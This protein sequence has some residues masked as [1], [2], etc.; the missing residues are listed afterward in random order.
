M[1]KKVKQIFS[2]KVIVYLITR[3]GTFFIQFISS[4]FLAVNCGAYYFGIWGFIS[5]LINYISYFNLGIPYSVNIL[6]IQNKSNGKLVKDY[7]ANSFFLNVLLSILIILFGVYYYVVGISAFDK[8]Q[9]SEYFY[10]ICVIGIVYHFDSLF[11]TI[12]RVNNR[13]FELAF[14]QSIVPVLIFFSI[15]LAKGEKLLELLLWMTLSGEL[16]ALLIF[17]VNKKIP[18]GGKVSLKGVRDV[19][20]KGFHLFI[21]NVCFFLIGLSTRTIISLYYRVEDFG[22]F[23]FSYNLANAILLFLQAL[24]VVIF[25]KIIDKLNSNK[26][27]DIIN[28][29]NI[30]NIN[31]VTLSYG[32]IFIAMIFFPIFIYFIPKYQ[33][34]LKLINLV[35]IS[36]LLFTN[37]FGYGTYLMAQNQEKRLSIIS[38]ISLILNIVISVL[39]VI[40]FKLTYEYL[41]LATLITYFVF[42][43]CC[44]LYSRK[45]LEQKTNPI[46]VI[47]DFFPLR[48]L[49]PYL[50]SVL[51]ILFNFT[52]LI[53]LPLLVFIVLNISEIKQIIGT[54]KVIILRPTIVDIDKNT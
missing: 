51:M 47:L 17:I 34:T 37:S 10:L 8:Y 28:V 52:Y 1:I 41:I 33:N 32:L 14:F 24:S 15:F 16:I 11:G 9:I 6:M 4:I 20:K 44:T 50:I 40:K 23:T 46:S 5:M 30:L 7:I 38:L 13:M 35:A 42:S 43:Y 49:I 45:I 26:K 22:Y 27:L 25:P 3:Y 19:L 12:Y 36:L 53:F 31:Y 39:L 2:N 21:Y 18:W 29:L 54:I 48:L